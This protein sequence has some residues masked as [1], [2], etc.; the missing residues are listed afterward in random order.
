LK[1]I[2]M[3][4]EEKKI[5]VGSGD[6][7]PTY[8]LSK[9]TLA[10]F[11]ALEKKI[12]GDDS[13]PD[14][15][16]GDSTSKKDVRKEDDAMNEDGTLKIDE[17]ETDDETTEEGVDEGD[18]ELK[19]DEKNDKE[20]DKKST[21]S[22]RLIQAARRNFLSD[23]DIE[24]LGDRAE[25]VLTKMA[26]NANKVSEQLGE[27]GRLK[28]QKALLDSKSTSDTTSKKLKIGE[29][30]DEEIKGI[31]E[32]HN[33]LLDEISTLKQ[34]VQTKETV[35]FDRRIDSFFDKKI[36]DYKEFGDSSNL[37]S[38]QELLR[39]D[40][41]EKADNILVGAS[42]KG[43]NLSVEQALEMSFGLYEKDH[44]K[45]SAKKEVVDKVKKRSKSRIS[46]PTSRKTEENKSSPEDKAKKSYAAKLKELGLTD[47]DIE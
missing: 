46:K 40:V 32:S 13:T 28:R 45:E 17:D 26:D 22:D 5:E 41:F 42:L 29:D 24:A 10:K 1:E 14:T 11:S 27:L 6:S 20:D 35:E 36:G 2:E 34:Q 39:K 33:N 43:Q 7:A 37:T 44:V 18:D 19:K 8:Q 9:D 12:N 25:A 38:T 23:E 21:L 15:G 30:Y 47:E 16:E 4:D 3:A 31:I